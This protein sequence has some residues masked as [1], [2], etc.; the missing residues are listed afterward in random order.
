MM[1]R[2]APVGRSLRPPGSAPDCPKAK[3]DKENDVMH[4]FFP[5]PA[6]VTAVV[7]KPAVGGSP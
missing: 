2:V 3:Y 7:A 4:V 1:R 6:L 5:S